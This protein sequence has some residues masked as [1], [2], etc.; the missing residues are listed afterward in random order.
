MRPGSNRL[1]FGGDF[2]RCSINQKLPKKFQKEPG[3]R[4][5]KASKV[6]PFYDR[7]Q[8]ALKLTFARSARR[9]LQLVKLKK[10]L[11]LMEKQDLHLGP[12]R[13]HG[14]SIKTVT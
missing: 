5:V 2:F 10:V 9:H 1:W 12:R 14:A 4:D 6:A 11:E 13:R 8:R 7:L 3:S